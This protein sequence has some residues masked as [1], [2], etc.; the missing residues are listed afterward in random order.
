MILEISHLALPFFVVYAELLLSYCP[1]VER[2]GFD[3]N[4][5]DITE[6]VDTRLA[7]TLKSNS[8]SFKGHVYNHFSKTHL[9]FVPVTPHAHLAHGN[10]E[11][12]Y[13][14]NP[15]L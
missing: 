5:M 4:Y 9:F 1:L 2:L 10:Q 15:K 11:M 3:E 13:E 14:K 12:S 6:M 7:Q 8:Y